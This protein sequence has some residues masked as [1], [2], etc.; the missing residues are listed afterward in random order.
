MIREVTIF[1]KINSLPQFNFSG[2][3]IF[4]MSGIEKSQISRFINGKIDLGTSKF[5]QLIRSMPPEFQQRYFQEALAM[6]IEV[7]ELKKSDRIPWT[8]MIG[9]ADYEDIEE[10]LSALAARW[11][12]LGKAKQKELVNVG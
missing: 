6:N 7:K 2:V 10:I 11:L 4:Q 9:S 12:E 8:E 1:N 5:F 3:E